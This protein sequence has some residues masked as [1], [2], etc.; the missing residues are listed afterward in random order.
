MGKT[1]KRGHFASKIRNSMLLSGVITVLIITVIT[2]ITIRNTMLNETKESV[3]DIAKIAASQINGDKFLSIDSESSEAFGEI[4]AALSCYL[5]GNSVG[6]IYTMKKVDDKWVFVVDADPNSPADVNEV[7]DDAVPAMDKAF[8]GNV[9][10]DSSIT[11]DEWG[12][13]MSGYAPIYSKD[14]KVVGIVGV[15]CL[16]KDINQKT[17]S[18]M[19][20]LIGVGIG[21][22]ILSIIIGNVPTMKLNNRLNQVN[23]KLNDVLFNDGDLN[24]KIDMKT[25]DE[26]EELADN[27]NAL[28]DQTR[29]V[30]RNVKS[31]SADIH[32]VAANVDESMGSANGAVDKISD[33]IEDM[34]GGIEVTVSSLEEI[35]AM[36]EKVETTVSEANEQAMSGAKLADDINDRSTKM[37]KE[38]T[39]SQ[40]QLISKVN[41]MSKDLGEKIESVKYVEKIQEFTEEI[42]SIA[43]NTKML[44]LNASIEA[45][46][47]G[48]MGK[49]FAVVATNIGELAESSAKSADNI[50]QVS[51]IIV[52]VVRDM[53]KVSQE[54]L[55]FV[56][57][58]VVKQISEFTRSGKEYAD[59]SSSILTVM[60]TFKNQMD[61]INSAIEEIGK[62]IEVVTE[63]S[64]DNNEKISQI[65]EHAK[66]LQNEMGYTSGR[67][68]ENRKYAD[69]LSSIVQR[70]SV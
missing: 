54:M 38:A 46:R 6:Y 51:G 21:C 31:C 8:A 39:K 53:V 26:F 1:K 17:N 27:L 40:E 42:L 58:N 56:N 22:I 3:A 18:L 60:E 36:M 37:T 70:Y 7:Y 13:F 45:A 30:V 23:S 62:A 67:S 69:D 44:A 32:L 59:S 68:Q 10:T 49:G 61:F 5:K 57:T 33:Y 43:N 63:A 15:D 34:S 12:S 9:T 35:K 19:I 64:V 25:N 65:S 28:L 14:G 66:E 16:A 29:D 55:D 4:H 24:K 50:R 47:A 41:S 11:T 2:G 52:D 20:I 48:E